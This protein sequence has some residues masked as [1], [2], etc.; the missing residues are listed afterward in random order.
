MKLFLTICL[1]LIMLFFGFS[2]Y[3]SEIKV[4]PAKLEVDLNKTTQTTFEVSNPSA[5]EV[6]KFTVY[7]DNLAQIFT[8]SDPEFFLEP[9]A[10]KEVKI[11]IKK[12]VF[13]KF[14]SPRLETKISVLSQN[15]S[16]TNTLSVAAGVKIPI[17][18]T[19]TPKSTQTNTKLIGFG[20]LTLLLLLL[21]AS[22]K[23]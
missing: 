9:G 23:K 18:I 15:L 22:G 14:Q 1:C 12:D 3:A 7:P 21:V 8:I 5:K 6:R 10:S 11:I 13:E 16:A 17:L 19:F 4:I 2:A 20:A